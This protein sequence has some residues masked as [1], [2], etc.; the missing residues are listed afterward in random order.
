MSHQ[1]TTII[2]MNISFKKMSFLLV[3]LGTCFHLG[4][5]FLI[6]G[7]LAMAK[8]RLFMAIL[9]PNLLLVNLSSHFKILSLTLAH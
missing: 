9:L 2:P 1:G 7:L 8:F 4:I 3:I 6:L 5:F